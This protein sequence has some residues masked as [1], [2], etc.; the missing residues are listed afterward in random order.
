MYLVPRLI[1]GTRNCS[2]STTVIFMTAPAY[3]HNASNAPAPT[4][5]FRATLNYAVNF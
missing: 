3:A 2:S 4:E 5:D 1:S